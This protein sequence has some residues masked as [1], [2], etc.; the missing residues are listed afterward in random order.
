MDNHPKSTP[1]KSKHFS[2]L[3]TIVSFWY[4]ATAAIQTLPIH[5]PAKAVRIC[6]KNLPKQEVMVG[7]RLPR[8]QIYVSH[9]LR[10]RQQTCDVRARIPHGVGGFPRGSKG[11]LAPLTIKAAFTSCQLGCEDH[12]SGLCPVK[13]KPETNK[14]KAW[15]Q[16]LRRSAEKSR[17]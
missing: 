15:K 8:S 7:G 16:S 13:A 6:R 10:M 12:V 17:T 5:S 14:A 3:S 11:E 2:R 1:H 9:T 4:P